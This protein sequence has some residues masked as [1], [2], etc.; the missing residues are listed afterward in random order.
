MAIRAYPGSAARETITDN[1]RQA[2][3]ALAAASGTT[4]AY[5]YEENEAGLRQRRPDLARLLSEKGL[6][7]ATDDGPYRP[8][9]ALQQLLRESDRGDVMLLTSIAQLAGLNH[10]DQQTLQSRVDG[11]AL[12]IVALDLPASHAML[13]KTRNVTATGTDTLNR[14]ILEMLTSLTRPAQGSQRNLQKQGIAWAKARGKYTGRPVDQNKH[15]AIQAM[16]AKG[17]TWS[18]VVEATGASR[19]TIA[20]VVKAAKR[21]PDP[22]AHERR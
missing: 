15:K 8:R 22:A 21:S 7:I 2:L 6:A 20:R 9:P 13:G 16:L 5:W 10:T 12:R 19:S 11:K 17:H 14:L 18:E 1:H 4:I 3:Q